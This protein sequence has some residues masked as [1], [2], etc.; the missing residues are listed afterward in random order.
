VVLNNFG[1]CG[2]EEE[3]L[4]LRGVPERSGVKRKNQSKNIRGKQFLDLNK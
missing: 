1:I 2:D 3:K 4:R